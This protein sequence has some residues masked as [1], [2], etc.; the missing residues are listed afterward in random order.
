MMKNTALVFLFFV[1]AV[2]AATAQ[3]QIRARMTGAPP[4]VQENQNS[5]TRNRTVAP[6]N[7]AANDVGMPNQPKPAWGDSVVPP[8]AR[9]T[10][11]TPPRTAE[12][13]DLPRTAVNQ[14]KLVK[15]TSLAINNFTTTRPAPAAPTTTYR[16]GIGDVLDIRLSN[17]ATRESTL[18]TVMKN[19]ALEY[20]L[21][22]QPLN[23]A[24]L[25]PDEIARRLS[26]EIKVIQNPR[27]SVSVRDYASHFVLISGA[28]D[29]PGRKV[30]RREAMPLFALLAEAL[31]RPDAATVTVVRSGKETNLSV[32]RTEEL[33]MLVMPGDLIRVSPASGLFVYVGGEVTSAGEKEL[34]QGMTLTQLLLAAGGV[35]Q[36]RQFTARISRRDGSGF[37]RT[38]DHN[39]KAIEQGKA[40]DPLLQA[41]DRIEV[42]SGM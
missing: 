5:S 27:A 22:A 6:N 40:A 31:P 2:P 12:T 36:D 38:Q 9:P 42:R 17:M 3:T 33:A 30:L 41:G 39:L 25:T 14:P 35:R 15:P 28:V 18:F 32:S 10:E 26:A 20:P 34:R 11:V 13:R 37:L 19:G 8:G 7:T 29:N 23:V 24:G 4:P 1:V 21:L 16:V